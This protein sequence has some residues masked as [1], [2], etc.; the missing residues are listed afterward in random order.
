MSTSASSACRR[1]GALGPHCA[2]SRR[3]GGDAPSGGCG[4]AGDA[5]ETSR[6]PRAVISASA[7]G[8]AGNAPAVLGVTVPPS[9]ARLVA[10]SGRDGRAARREH[11][12]PARAACRRAWCARDGCGAGRRGGR[13]T[14]A[15]RPGWPRPD[16]L[17]R[18]KCDPIPTEL[19]Q[20]LSRMSSGDIVTLR[21]C[22]VPSKSDRIE[23]VRVPQARTARLACRAP[24]HDRAGALVCSLVRCGRAASGVTRQVIP[25]LLGTLCVTRHVNAATNARALLVPT[26]VRHASP[27][28]RSRVRVVIRDDAHALATPSAAS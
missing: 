2:S 16:R 25:S 7:I 17:R 23:R 28:R 3:T 14:G 5:G 8:A 22:D 21:V 20:A 13:P 1:C 19:R 10:S 26:Q 11:H 15:P 24:R 4:Q 27:A 18:R 6:A 12:S 9:A